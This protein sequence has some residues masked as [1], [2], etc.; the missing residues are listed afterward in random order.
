MWP[1]I[2]PIAS[3]LL[4]DEESIGATVPAKEVHI[5]EMSD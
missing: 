5:A 3:I 1:S 4:V 2:E